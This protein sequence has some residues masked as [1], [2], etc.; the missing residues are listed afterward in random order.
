MKNYYLLLVI[1]S[2]TLLWCMPN[3]ISAQTWQTTDITFSSARFEDMFFLTPT[4]GYIVNGEGFI[5]RTEDGGDHWQGVFITSDY[6][7]S[8]EFLDTEVG[9]AGSL[10][11]SLFRTTNGGANWLNITGQIPGSIS[12][13]CGMSHVGT[14]TI[15]GVGTFSGDPVFIRSDNQG[16]DWTYKD[17]SDLVSGLVEVHFFDSQNGLI[18][19]ISNNSGAV[20]LRTEDGGETWEN[21]FEANRVLEFV[22][23]LDA[24][25]DNL[26]YGAIENYLPEGNG[27]YIVKS[28]DGGHT[29]EEKLVSNGFH[30]LQ[31]IGFRNELE[32]WVCPRNSGMFHTLDGGETWSQDNTISNI[33]RIWR[34]DENLLYACGSHFYRNG[35]LP[36]ETNVISTEPIM[37]AISGIAPNPFGES[38]SF[39]VQVPPSGQALVEV[40]NQEGKLMYRWEKRNFPQ[41]ANSFTLDQTADW[42]SGVY[43]LSVRC[44]EGHA[45]K[46]II[47]R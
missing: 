25:D 44:K 13:I 16:D 34:V 5:Y 21:V 37:P 46:K 26:I 10:D 8:I 6:L 12:G 7:R 30:D 39:T 20:I 14:Q 29:W 9:F 2:L 11:G 4:L 41:G 36:T 27:R 43:Y 28:E 17:M 3:S 1:S 38:L 15:I 18:G 23:K 33:N 40:I 24:L 22:W 31:G 45:G 19:G 35:N 42:P 47:K 32:G